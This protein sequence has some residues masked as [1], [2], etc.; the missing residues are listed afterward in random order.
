MQT[1]KYGIACGDIV[2]NKVEKN[3]CCKC[4]GRKGL[5][6]FRRDD[7]TCKLCL[8]HREQWAGNNTERVEELWQKYHEENMDAHL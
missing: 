8:A 2:V 6:M 7:A 3:Q 4:K 1:R 5:E